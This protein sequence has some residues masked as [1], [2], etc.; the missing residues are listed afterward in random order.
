MAT[1][2]QTDIRLVVKALKDAARDAE[3]TMKVVDQDV[4]SVLLKANR[5]GYEVYA[6]GDFAVIKISMDGKV[7]AEVVVR[8][9]DHNMIARN[10][11]QCSWE[12]EKKPSLL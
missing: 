4:D 6:P 11:L 2:L 7:M 10:I 12:Q 8:H 3:I 1:R 9:W 5:M